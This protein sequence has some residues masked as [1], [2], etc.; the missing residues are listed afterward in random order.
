VTGLLVIF[1]AAFILMVGL[2]FVV[3]N[4]DK[5]PQQQVRAEATITPTPLPITRQI[6]E[7]AVLDVNNL[8]AGWF[9]QQPPA[10]AADTPLGYAPPIYCGHALPAASRTDAGKTIA[11]DKPLT[12]VARFQ[13]GTGP[14]GPYFGQTIRAYPP[15]EGAHAWGLLVDEIRACS[16]FSRTATCPRSVNTSPAPSAWSVSE[17]SFSQSLGVRAIAFRIWSE[18]ECGGQPLVLAALFERDDVVQ[19]V[20]LVT[21]GTGDGNR[22]E[23]CNLAHLADRQFFPLRGQSTRLTVCAS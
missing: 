18:A 4:A 22:K 1:A 10:T 8:P 2:W 19:E 23:L 7:S 11:N 3:E 14:A 21:N 17:T 5:Q 6:L 16:N 13:R 20:Y 12:A 9:V 15:G